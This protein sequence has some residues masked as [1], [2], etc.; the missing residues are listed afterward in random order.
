MGYRKLMKLFGV[1]I[2]LIFYFPAISQDEIITR[3]D[4]TKQVRIVS[5]EK[6]I[7]S[8]YLVND[9]EKSI[10]QLEKK[11][12][13]KIKYD[14]PLSV[15]NAVVITDDS[16]GG[17]DLFSHIVS[18]LI[19]SGFEMNTFDMEHSTVSV[20]T[21]SNFRLSVEIDGN[22]ALF[23]GYVPEKKDPTIPSQSERNV[24]RLVP[25]DEKEPG[26]I[27]YPGE[28]IINAADSQFK[29][30]DRICR[31]YL[32]HNKGLLNYIHE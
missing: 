19:E 1:T 6:K 5:E 13:K 9:P 25:R 22:R 30:I 14:T 28:E 26:E 12:I 3:D 7:V 16:L 32:M 15:M 24:I 29:E 4:E 17:E 31:N 18:Y 11:E 23:S 2:L 10:Q 20:F 27:K 8:F 21:S